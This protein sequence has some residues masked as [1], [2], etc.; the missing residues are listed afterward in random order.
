MSRPL[1]GVIAPAVLVVASMVNPALA[2]PPAEGSLL[3]GNN[4][5]LQEFTY[6]GV[7]V[8]SFAVPYPGGRPGTEWTRDLT[9][10]RDG[11][12][13]VFNGTFQPYLSVLNPR[14]GQWGHFSATGW[15]IINNVSYG[16]IATWGGYVYVGDQ[17]L[18]N[19]EG[20]FRFDIDRG[21]TSEQ[22]DGPGGY[23]DVVTGLNG[24]LYGLRSD[25]MKVDERDPGNLEIR[26]TIALEKAVRAVAINA[27]GEIY[28]ASWDGLLYQF[29]PSGKRMRT[30]N[31]G[32]T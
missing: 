8:R 5:E 15:A 30:M 21:Y 3:V 22:F 10:D 24:L 31:T 25:E 6:D 14:T 12:V 28:G 32:L 16:G 7:F 27:D 2:K 17:A 18:D 4:N 20:V 11:Q 26:R 23:I 29:E 13:N 19:T 1:V 9:V